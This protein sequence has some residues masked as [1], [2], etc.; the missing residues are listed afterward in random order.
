MA[1]CIEALIGAIYIDQGNER[2]TEFIM[3]DLLPELLDHFEQTQIN[4]AN[5]RVFELVD[6]SSEENSSLSSS[7]EEEEEVSQQTTAETI[8]K[9]DEEKGQ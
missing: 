8:K 6:V 7:E 9:E 3:S 1:S 4:K 2:A 5:S